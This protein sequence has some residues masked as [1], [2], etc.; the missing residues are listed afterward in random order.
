MLFRPESLHSQRQA[1]LGS[2]QVMQP[3][4]L[5]WLTFGVLATL[6]AV[7]TFLFLGE[8]PRT[9]RLS[10]LVLPQMGWVRVVPPV[11]GRLLVVEVEEGQR[12]AQGA[13]LFTLEV[14]SPQWGETT[15]LGL[16]QSFEA[17]RRSLDEAS[18]QSQML[19]L[20][21]SRGLAQR[22]AAARREAAVL[23]TQSALQQQRQAL[24][25][26]AVARLEALV[27]EQFVS[28]AQVQE[29]TGEL[30]SSRAEGA[31]IARQREALDAEIAALEAQT[32]Q[33]PLLTAQ[34]M[35]ELEREQGELA[36]LA[37]REN[38]SQQPRRVAVQAPVAGTLSAVH[39]SRGQA[40]SPEAAVLTLTPEDE[41]LVAHLYAPSSALG[42]VRSGQAVKL[43]V[44]AFPHQKFGWLAGQVSAVAQ[45]PAQATEWAQ[46]AGLGRGAG[47]EPLYRITVSLSQT[48]LTAAGAERPLRAGMQLDADVVLE[49]RRLYEWL[50]E[51]VLAWAKR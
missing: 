14:V 40:V 4:G 15:S 50:F 32:R 6:V 8:L 5:T 45:A 44:A 20:E 12:V 35:G 11:A 19:L 16:R 42:F 26:R 43:R 18:K 41:P 9:T 23:A 1:W 48:H 37:T 29:K 27:A 39:A 21:Q 24:A 34:R 13:A 46:V 22:L 36:E 51:P 10:G 17:R 7:S 31:A 2:I 28:A 33:L 49:Q 25:E 3:L 30:L 38:G 47:T